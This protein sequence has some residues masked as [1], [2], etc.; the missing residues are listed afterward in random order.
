M[1]EVIYWELK[2]ELAFNLITQDYKKG[3]LTLREVWNT[4]DIYENENSLYRKEFRN[5]RHRCDWIDRGDAGRALE[6]FKEDILHHTC[7][8]NFLIESLKNDLK[9]RGVEIDYKSAGVDN[10]GVFSTDMNNLGNPDF[11]INL[12]GYDYIDVKNTPVDYKATFKVEELD[13]AL[14]HRACIVLF[15]NTGFLKRPFKLSDGVFWTIFGTKTIQSLKTMHR[16]C[17]FPGMGGKLSVMVG[18][19][20]C[21]YNLD[22]VRFE[23]VFKLY[24]LGDTTKF[25]GVIDQ[26]IDFKGN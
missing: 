23:E 10:S 22:V 24:K 6:D 18:L 4:F 17:N 5:I 14:R 21:E 15:A 7:K 19:G 2:P 25:E 11:K 13:R 12:P 20:R 8:E 3:N 9:N 26:F 16:S 1:S